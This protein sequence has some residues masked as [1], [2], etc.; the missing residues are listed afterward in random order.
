MEAHIDIWSDYDK[1]DE[2]GTLIES[3]SIRG[4]VPLLIEGDIVSVALSGQPGSVKCEI[5]DV[6][7]RITLT[8]WVVFYQLELL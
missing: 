4:P 7:H 6:K 8:G 2:E 5:K 1:R 3:R